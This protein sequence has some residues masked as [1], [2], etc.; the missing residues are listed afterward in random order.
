MPPFPQPFHQDSS[1]LCLENFASI[2]STKSVCPVCKLS[3]YFVLCKS[4]ILPPFKPCKLYG[5]LTKLFLKFVLSHQLFVVFLCEC[6]CVN[7]SPYPS[8]SAYRISV[9][10]ETLKCREHVSFIVFERIGSLCVLLVFSL[11]FRLPY[12]LTLITH[13][14]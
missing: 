2:L 6:L 5:T 8:Q 14:Q 4:R 7:D 12:T 11:N 3:F 10:I 13:V 1:S 9:S